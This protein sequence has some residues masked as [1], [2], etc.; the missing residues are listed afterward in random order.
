MTPSPFP[1]FNI[2]LLPCDDAHQ[3]VFARLAQSYFAEPLHDYLLGDHALAH[4]TLCQFRAPDS[5]AAGDAFASWIS[6]DNPD[7][8]SALLSIAYF[9]YKLRDPYPFYWA[10]LL[11]QASSALQNLQQRC[12][13]HLRSI[14][15]EVLTQREPFSPHITLAC[16]ADQ[17]VDVNAVTQAAPQEPI[18]FRL[19]VGQ[20]SEYGVFIREL[21]VQG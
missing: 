15:I 6:H 16:T 11:I 1:R 9:Q 10:E 13:D 3:Q 8:D 21:A 20:S 12:S 14:A 17:S 4:V 2:A 7:R 5:K 18:P 19:G